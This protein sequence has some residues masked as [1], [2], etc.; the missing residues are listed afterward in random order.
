MGVGC[1]SCMFQRHVCIK[2]L[3]FCGST[4]PMKLHVC[5]CGCYAAMHVGQS[6]LS[7]SA[8]L[9]FAS[10]PSCLTRGMYDCTLGSVH[11]PWHCSDTLQYTVA[12]AHAAAL[13]PCCSYGMTENIRIICA[14]SCM[15]AGVCAAH[16]RSNGGRLCQEETC[17]GRAHSQVAHALAQRICH[18]GRSPGDHRS[19][20]PGAHGLGR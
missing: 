14:A 10:L 17:L 1:R 5:W 12:V 11:Q 3:F 8:S 7:W 6:R 4:R 18:A 15:C 16:L 2:C 19:L 13:E 20:F 9:P